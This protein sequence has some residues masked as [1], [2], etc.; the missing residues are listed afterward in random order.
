MVLKLCSSSCFCTCFLL[1]F[2]V[3]IVVKIA[4]LVTVVV[5]RFMPQITPTVVES[6]GVNIHGGGLTCFLRVMDAWSILAHPMVLILLQPR[7]NQ[8]KS[9][10]NS[11]AV[12]LF[13]LG[14]PLVLFLVAVPGACRRTDDERRREGNRMQ[15]YLPSCL[16]CCLKLSTFIMFMIMYTLKLMLIK[17]SVSTPSFMLHF[18][19]TRGTVGNEPTPF[20]GD[21]FWDY[22]LSLR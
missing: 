2:S 15:I 18:L 6:L 19:S 5:R 10:S 22:K 14:L 16:C 9:D 20:L 21:R 4:V 1:L 12:P 11:T 8:I 3:F 7:R 13:V 17:S